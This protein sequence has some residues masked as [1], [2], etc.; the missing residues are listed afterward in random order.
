MSNSNP[1]KSYYAI[2]P[3][4]VRYDDSL[5]PNAKLLYGEITA[6]CNEKGY[7]WAS[8]QYFGKLYKV[9]NVTISKWVN[10]LKRAGYIFVQMSA[11]QH[12]TERRIAIKESNLPNQKTDT[13]KGVLKKSLKGS[14][15]KVKGGL[16]EKFIHNSTDNIKKNNKKSSSEEIFIN[17]FKNQ[18][19]NADTITSYLVKTTT[20]PKEKIKDFASYFFNRYGIPDTKKGLIISFEKWL[21]FEKK[22]RK[23][24]AP[25]KERKQMSESENVTFKKIN[26]IYYSKYGK[27]FTSFEKEL[28]V[29]EIKKGMTDSLF[30]YHILTVHP[31]DFRYHKYLV[32]NLIQ[33]CKK[34]LE[35]NRLKQN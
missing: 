19:S 29:T 26:K 33:K 15:R 2:I 27:E 23:K 17:F 31:V 13:N 24:V 7:C 18:N 35:E 22:E 11:N 8:N 32:S 25:K 6:L 1:H 28:I 10:Q 34:S 21:S 3:A 12:G 14:L 20:I 5:T 9:S 16:K 30:N 4:D